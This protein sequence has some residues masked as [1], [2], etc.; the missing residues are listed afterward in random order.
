MRPWPPPAEAMS[1]GASTEGRAVVLA[2]RNPHKVVEMQR[3]LEPA[4]IA[5]EALPDELE[6]P[7]EDGT[8]FADNALV[9]A[10]S[11]GRRHRPAVGRRRLGHRSHGARRRAR[12]PLGAVCGRERHR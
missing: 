8:T 5:V 2:T 7:P 3:L 11:R 12:D 9:K 10:R 6:L 1:E 4:G